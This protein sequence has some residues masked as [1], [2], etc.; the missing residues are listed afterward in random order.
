[1]SK[2]IDKDPRN[3]FLID[4]LGAAF[5]A[6]VCAAAL[7]R[8]EN[9]FGIPARVPYS[10][11]VVAFCFSVYSLLCYFIEP[12]SWRIFLRAIAAANLSYCA[13]TAF[14]LFYHRETATFYCVAYF[15]SEK[16]VV[17]FLAAQEL[18]FS[19]HGSFRE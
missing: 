7:A 15:I 3:L 5:S 12:E 14:L 10:L 18:R 9:V 19:L 6:F 8:F 1:M 16:V 13:A 2:Y 17:S 11:S 4:G